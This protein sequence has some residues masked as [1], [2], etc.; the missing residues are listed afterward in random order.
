M[1]DFSEVS[2]T[3]KGL[4]GSGINALPFAFLVAGWVP[5]I[6]GM[7][8]ITLLTLSTMRLTVLVSHSVK[9]RMMV[10][11]LAAAGEPLGFR[12]VSSYLM[13]KWGVFLV[14]TSLIACQLGGNMAFV[15]FMISNLGAITNHSISN[16]TLML[17]LFP[18]MLAISLLPNTRLLSPVSHLGN[19]AL[20]LAIA[21]VFSVGFSSSTKAT[22]VN[23]LQTEPNFTDTSG[24]FLFIGIA[25]FALCGHAEVL[26]ISMDSSDVTNYMRTLNLCL[27]ALF[28]AY[29][30]FSIISIACFGAQTAS[31]ILINLGQSGFVNIVRGLMTIVVGCNVSLNFQV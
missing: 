10:H 12:Q 17:W 5:G 30:S 26:S 9:R 27:L 20:L 31:N 14:D 23:N 11:G 13:G 18:M 25:A 24:L 16:S 2:T 15:A 3:L 29:T 21:T 8:I 28:F 4:S 7:T 6:V 22:L 19:V 1:I